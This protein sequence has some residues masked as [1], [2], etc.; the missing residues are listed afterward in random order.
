MGEFPRAAF[1]FSKRMKLCVGACMIVSSAARGA[2]YGSATPSGT[3]G[4]VG[5]S[6]GLGGTGRVLTVLV[7]AGRS[8]TSIQGSA[9]SDGAPRG[10]LAQALICQRCVSVC[11]SSRS[12]GASRAHRRLLTVGTWHLFQ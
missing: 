6:G 12:H 3:R 5:G 1:A 10:M 8:R 2:E 11:T 9:Q 4:K 7:G